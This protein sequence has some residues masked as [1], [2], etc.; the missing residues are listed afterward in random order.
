M[1]QDHYDIINI[2]ASFAGLTLAHHLPPHYRVLVIDK[3]PA[4]NYYV[5]STGLVTQATR[6]MLASFTNVDR[7]IPNRITTIGVVA[8]DYKKMFFSHT[9]EPWIYSTDTPELVQHMSET[10]P[11]NVT[12]QLR[13]T[14]SDVNV[15]R[16]QKYP[17]EIRYQQ[18]GEQK[19][20]RVRFMVGADGSHSQVAKKNQHLSQNTKFLAGLEKV[21]FGDITLGE[22]PKNTVYHFWFGAFSLGYGG[23]LSPTIVKGKPAFRLGLAKL[24]K[25]IKDLEKINQFIA[26]L[27][28][29]NMIRI[30][31]GTEEILTF[32]SLIPIGGPL[33]NVS[34]KHTLLIGDAAGLC[35]A[36]AADGIKGAV[37]SAKV[38]AEIIPEH[39]EGNARALSEF[40]PRIQTYK[41]LMTYY[42]KQQLYRLLW[43]KMKSNRT[44]EALFDIIARQ[45]ESFLHQFC[46]SKDR[47]SSLFWVIVRPGSILHLL[48]YSWFLLLDM[49]R[50]TK[51]ET[52][53]HKKPI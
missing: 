3:K 43:N 2:G 9:K 35:G 27:Q 10:L 15:D 22:H 13:A 53:F 39:L 52:S 28:E 42:R 31:Q 11:N 25:D 46:D 47:N 14:F 33:R 16:E 6:D 30:E 24:K 29:K 40:Y 41:S 4:L 5:E 18:N 45:K 34:D 19:L 23:W 12:L 51:K 36:F 44:F 17:V 21:F 1:H 20:V 7:F 26:T 37:V 38:A 48:K 50:Q 49:I 8:P 32:G